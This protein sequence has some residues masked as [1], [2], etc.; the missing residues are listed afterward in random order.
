[1]K[2]KGGWR[3]W[4]QGRNSITGI[5]WHPC[6]TTTATDQAGLA[7]FHFPQKK[8]IDRAILIRLLLRSSWLHSST[9][10]Y[11]HNFT[12]VSVSWKIHIWKTQ[13]RTLLICQAYFGKCQDLGSAFFSY[14]FLREYR[15]SIKFIK[16]HPGKKCLLVRSGSVPHGDVELGEEEESHC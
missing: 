9:D 5:S 7:F 1:M 16:L 2:S 6:T 3:T 8:P 12:F 14:P 15:H 10:I 4:S 11:F 13:Q